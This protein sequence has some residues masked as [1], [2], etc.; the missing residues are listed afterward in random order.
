[1]I[2]KNRI[3][4]IDLGSNSVRM[5]IYE[6]E[7]DRHHLLDQAEVKVRISEG[8]GEEL[9]IKEKP[10][11]RLLSTLTLF[12]ELIDAYEVHEVYPIA[13]AAVRTAKNQKE[14]L[15]KIEEASGF[16]FE[17]ISGKEEAKLDY[18]GVINSLHL[19]DCVII[20][21]GGASTE[22]I[23]VQGREMKEAVSLSFGSVNLTENTDKKAEAKT[24]IEDAFSKVDFLE[25]A[26]GYPIVSLGGTI[27]TLAKMHREDIDWPIYTIHGYEMKREDVLEK[28][29][30]IKSSKTEEL[31]EI[32]GVS[33]DRVDILKRGILPFG[34]LFTMLDSPKL[35]IS[36]QG[37]RDGKLYKTIFKKKDRI[38]NNLISE[39]I[40]QM[41]HR[42]GL[43]VDNG[44]TVSKHALSLYDALYDK[45]EKDLKKLLGVAAELYNVG[46]HMDYISQELHG[47]YLLI[48][49]DFPGLSTLERIKVAFIIAFSGMREHR[50]N[51]KPYMKLI[52][53]AE[54]EELK[55]ISLFLALARKLERTGV[56]KINDIKLKDQMLCIHRGNMDTSLEEKSS[57]PVIAEITQR[58]GKKIAFCE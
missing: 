32:P 23:L 39:G 17:V 42:Y 41:K 36:M 27:R 37:V 5:N 30:E 4:I 28:L 7:E 54:R 34:V 52:S 49:S 21:L 57:E 20:D 13:T 25:K 29:K 3:A 26:K 58:Y 53:G 51:L 44:K 15:N 24:M 38:N 48:Q 40:L 43:G 33:L 6:V 14:I 10:L 9:T 35:I 56:K 8:M 18:L 55:D 50:L 11:E 31:K 16:S 2:E 45:K 1:M 12:K 47:F 19:K 22:L 46:M